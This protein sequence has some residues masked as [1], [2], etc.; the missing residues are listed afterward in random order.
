MSE[1]D[2]YN[3]TGAWPKLGQRVEIVEAMIHGVIVD[4]TEFI[5]GTHRWGVQYW[6]EGKR[7]TVNCEAR[8]LKATP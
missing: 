6:N 2:K 7:E 3:E 5:D 4:H 8:E 1:E